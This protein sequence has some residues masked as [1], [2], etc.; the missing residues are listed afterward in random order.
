M[1]SFNPRTI[2]AAALVSAFGIAGI[3]TPAAAEDWKCYTYQAAPASP[4]NIGLQKM[5][6][7]I[8]A[9]T[10]GRVTVKCSVGGALPIDANSIAPAV[11]DGILDFVSIA[12]ISGYVPLAAIG[13][14]PGL[15]SSNAEF[16]AKGWPV[17]KPIVDAEFDK[18]GIKLLGIYHYPPQVVFGAK[19][20]PP[21]KALA[22][23]NGKTLRIGNPEQGDLAK[24]LGAIPV[25]LPTPDVSPALQRGAVQYVVTAAA[26]GGR[27][28][29]DFFASGI[30]DPIFVATS[31]VAVSKRRWNALS[32]EEQE[33]IQKS[34]DETSA[35]ITKSQE[36]D[37][38]VA[39]KEFIEKD[40]WTIVPKSAE[41]QRE[42]AKV[43]EPVWKKWAEDRGPAAVKTLSDLRSALG[44][45]M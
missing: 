11:S 42:I 7:A 4:V 25:T 36:D 29:R 5:A 21:L 23:L 32:K 15:Y 10:K 17:L 8:N 41:V 12:N 34:V 28:W 40:K 24:A 19:G 45:P 33:A 39:L 3:S 30:M 20:A 37:D 31:Y 44:H 9:I 26:S 2:A 14:L 16:D 27:L 13:L 43:M 1:T 6:D 35:W 38:T 18:R 22:D